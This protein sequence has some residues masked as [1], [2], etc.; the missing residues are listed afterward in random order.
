M[1][2]LTPS[3]ISHYTEYGTVHNDYIYMYIYVLCSFRV[4]IESCSTQSPVD[5]TIIKETVSIVTYVWSCLREEDALTDTNGQLQVQIM[6]ELSSFLVSVA[7][8][9]E[10]V[11]CMYCTC[12]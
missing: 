9:G 1:L 6:M 12:T 11:L 5:T 2:N 4:F 3:K 10:T 7:Q 8:N